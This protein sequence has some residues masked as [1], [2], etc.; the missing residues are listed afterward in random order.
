MMS[1]ADD[2]C[3]MEI[4]MFR[5]IIAIA[6]RCSAVAFT[7][8][9]AVSQCLA[10]SSRHLAKVYKNDFSMWNDEEEEKITK[11][12]SFLLVVYVLMLL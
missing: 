3:P 4:G 12:G 1:I 11:F 9:N 6:S 8:Y 7:T 2:E 10:H 5:I